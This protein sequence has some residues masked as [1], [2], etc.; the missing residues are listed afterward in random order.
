MRPTFRVLTIAIAVLVVV[1]AMM[2]A[3]AVTG[4]F[5]W[6]D[7]D[8]GSIDKA[9]IDSWEDDPPTFTGSIGAFLH[10]FIVGTVLIPLTTLLTLIASF[11]A[12]KG[13]WKY[14]LALVVLVALQITLPSIA[15]PYGGLVHGLNA[16]LIFGTAIA[17]ARAARLAGEP[18]MAA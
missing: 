12:F 5:H 8:G 15:P 11:F 1:Q 13:A 4:L 14:G 7:A 18:A 3:F 2:I 9:V 17:A 16:F 6:I 10:F